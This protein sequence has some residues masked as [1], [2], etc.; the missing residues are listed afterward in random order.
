MLVGMVL[1]QNT[2]WKNVDKSLDN[3]NK[4]TNFELNKLLA[5]DQEELQDLIQPSGFFRNK[6]IY[7]HTLLKAYRDDFEDWE[8]LSTDNLR[9]KLLA[10]K[11]DRQ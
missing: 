5:L 6:A 4:V 8:R 10:L 2:N 3:L 11:G 7:L 9:K 1:I